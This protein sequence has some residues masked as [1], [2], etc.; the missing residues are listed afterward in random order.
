[1]NHQDIPE[2]TPDWRDAEIASLREQNSLLSRQVVELAQRCKDQSADAER[3]AR[4]LGEAGA[5]RDRLRLA[6]SDAW[7]RL[8]GRSGESVHDAAARVTVLAN[9]RAEA[10]ETER[11]ALKVENERLRRVEAAAM[12]LLGWKLEACYEHLTPDEQA[13]RRA[14][15][16]AP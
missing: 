1:M 5:E 2:G 8:G 15:V 4:E 12:A 3:L 14:I 9:A 7:D 11:D 6:N 10:L 16:G 13:L